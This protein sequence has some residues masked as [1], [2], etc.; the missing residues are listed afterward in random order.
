M[1]KETL[2]QPGAVLI[3]DAYIVT[4]DGTSFSLKNFMAEAVL[5]ENMELNGMSA[6]I[7][8][9]DSNGLITAAPF[10]GQ[11]SIVVKF[12]T[13][14]FDSSINI[15]FIV[16]SIKHRTL[17][18]D[19]EQ[20]YTLHCVT[21][22]LYSDSFVRLNS[23]YKGSTDELVEKIFD[24]VKSSSPIGETQ[25]NILGTPHLSQNYEFVAN[26]WS[27]FKCLNHIASKSIGSET[28]K[29]NF[30]FYETKAGFYFASPEILIK[31]QKEKRI[32]Y[33]EYNVQQN[34]TQEITQ[35]NRSAS[36]NYISPFISSRFNQVESIYFPTFK[37][38]I[39]A[40]NDGYTASS[41]FSYDLTTKRMAMMKFDSRPE[42]KDIAKDD[43]RYLGENFDSFETISKINPTPQNMLGN[44]LANRT[45]SPMATSP[46]GSSFHRGVEQIRNTLVRRYGDAELQNQT[47][48]ITVP[49]K[50]DVETGM[51]V[52]LVY[53]RTVEKGD[54]RVD[55]EELEDP[56]IS[57]IYL[58]TG[59]RHDISNGQH[60]MTLSIMKDSLGDF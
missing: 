8:I 10:L 9:I 6:E 41:I 37:D 57:G 53:P 38:Q 13:P 14:T 40:Q 42:S 1:S 7:T 56:Y 25:V 11:E 29:S 16:H 50:T 28:S 60:S 21:P 19:R 52:R 51:L 3:E 22:E 36:Y 34:Q 59:V 39:K 32:V 4:N 23:K 47:L 30:K 35:D 48:E 46:F 54:T 12:R 5:Y 27:P 15:A 17:N 20:F 44:P 43:R 2:R 58:I 33:D 24:Q 55:R 49:G 18:N 31:Q 45:F 26:Y